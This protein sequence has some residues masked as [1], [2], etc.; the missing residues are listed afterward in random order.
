MFRQEVQ[1]IREK[2]TYSNKWN[3]LMFENLDYFLKITEICAQEEGELF[4]SQINLI[5]KEIN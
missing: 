4:Y 3:Y 2:I 5:V 1:N